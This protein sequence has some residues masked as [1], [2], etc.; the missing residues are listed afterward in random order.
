MVKRERGLCERIIE[1][2]MLCANEAVATLLY[3]KKIPCVYRIH[4]EPTEEKLSAFLEFVHNLGFDTGVISKKK[5]SAGDFANLLEEAK[6]REISAQLSYVML[7][8]MSKARYSDVCADHFGLALSRYCHFTSPIRRLSDFATHRIIRE[9]LLS[10]KPTAR[11][12]S[13]ARR[14]AVSATDAELR[15]VAAERKIENLYKVIYMEEFI[16]KQFDAVVSSVG[17]FGFFVELENT[18]EGLVP[19]S[20]LDGPFVFE[21]KN[22]ALRLGRTVYKLGDQV[23]VTLEEADRIRGKLRFSL[24]SKK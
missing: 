11:Y 13:Y 20:T 23:R 9:V 6:R 12:A 14:A 3:E 22:Y 16:G 5:K 4:E 24:S 7:R 8:S 2:F 10:D 1:Q 21:E 18:C 15:A 17:Q 19:I